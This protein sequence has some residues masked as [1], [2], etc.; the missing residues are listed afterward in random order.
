[1]YIEVHLWVI[2]QYTTTTVIEAQFQFFII[3][4]YICPNLTNQLS[5]NILNI[6]NQVY[7]FTTI[8][9]I[10]TKVTNQLLGDLKY[11]ITINFNILMTNQHVHTTL[12]HL[13]NS[14]H[15]NE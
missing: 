3:G 2:Q 11:F 10:I 14:V 7:Q 8:M 9:F 6:S 1:M 4:N 13:I 15:S 5:L 12:C